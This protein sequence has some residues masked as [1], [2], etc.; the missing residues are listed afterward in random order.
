[1]KQILLTCISI[2][3]ISIGINAQN[4]AIQNIDPNTGEEPYE[5]ASGDLDGDGDMDIV[6]ATYNYNDGTPVQDYIKWYSNDGSGSFTIETT[7]SSTIRYVDGLIIADI[8]G[9][10]GDDII[11]TSVNQNKLVYFLSDGA[12]GFGLETSVDSAINSPGEVIAADLN[13]D[14]NM[15][16][17]TVSYGNERTQW[18][19]GDGAGGFTPQTHIHDGIFD[20][21][22]GPYFVKAGDL[23]GDTDIDVV[24]GYVDSQSIVIYYNQFFGSGTV[25]WIKDTVPV[26]TGGS[27][28]FEIGIGD[29]NNDGNMNVFKVDFTS[30]DV[31]WYS[32]I[33]NG[34]SSENIIS[35]DTIINN[36]G[37]VLVAD[38]DNDMLNDVIVTDGGVVDDA[39][40]WFK[41]ASNASP[42]TIP[43]LVINNNFQ[44]F[45]I[46]VEDFDGDLDQDIATIG[47]FS[48]TVDWYKNDLITLSVDDSSFET[49]NIY[50]NPTK[51]ILHFKG[52]TNEYYNVSISDFLGKKILNTTVN[53]NNGLDVSQLNSGIYII[54]FENNNTTYKFIKE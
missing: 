10:F 51:D 46:T 4:F 22:D 54:K 43:T 16:L 14:G 33:V 19:L 25:S 3:C 41:G 39:M 8:D 12:G 40:I 11:A 28:L 7:V 53:A 31:A 13:E 17:I 1:M 45:D 30:G 23:D 2:L 50:P 42:S 9:Q 36:P 21:D 52:L 27:Y 26:D 5:I 44:M 20:G 24:V 48:D 32:K 15:D 34:A 29:V 49:L 6:M 38:I 18:Y 35:D 37:S 47:N